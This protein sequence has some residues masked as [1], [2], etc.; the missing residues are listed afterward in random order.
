M[1][2]SCFEFFN[3]NT[4]VKTDTDKLVNNIYKQTKAKSIFKKQSL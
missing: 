3:F 1:L 4:L 2:L